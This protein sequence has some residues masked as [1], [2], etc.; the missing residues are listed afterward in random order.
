V[1]EAR[2]DEARRWLDDAMAV[3]RMVEAEEKAKRAAAK[4]ASRRRE[5][6]AARSAEGSGRV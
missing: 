3:L 2:I 6:E 1:G 5:A 4:A